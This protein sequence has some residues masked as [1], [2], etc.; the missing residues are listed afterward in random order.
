MD[1][2]L[3]GGGRPQLSKKQREVIVSFAA[4]DVRLI[5]LTDVARDFLQSAL[6]YETHVWNR[7]A[8]ER[9]GQPHQPQDFIRGERLRIEAAQG[10]VDIVDGESHAVHISTKPRA[11]FVQC[12]PFLVDLRIGLGLGLSLGVARKRR[13]K[14]LQEIRYDVRPNFCSRRRFRHSRPGKSVCHKR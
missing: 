8:G 13:R 10:G 1:A 12:A 2:F 3:S 7:F 11:L 5:R 6:I 4:D 9:I 14:C